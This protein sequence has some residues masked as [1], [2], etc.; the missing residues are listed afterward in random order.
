MG[1]NNSKLKPEVLNDLLK[2]TE[3]TERELQEWL[4]SKVV[5]L[6][7]YLINSKK[8]PGLPKGLPERQSDR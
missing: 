8:V 5:L 1:K 7:K 6:I 3:F 2:H 4:V